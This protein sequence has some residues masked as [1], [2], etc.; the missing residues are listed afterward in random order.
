MAEQRI[1]VLTEG[2]S[3]PRAAKTATS[4]I[5]YR[6]DEVVA[7]LDSTQVGQTSQTLLGVGGD[8]PVV[9]SLGDAAAADTLLIG[10]SPPGGK[11]PEE[12]RRVILDAISRGMSVVSGLHDFLV[13]DPE[14]V[15]AAEE[16]RV[17]LVDVRKNDERIVA[18][19]REFNPDCLR[20]HTV[21][22]DCTVGK[23]LTAIDITN[24]LKLQGHDAKFVATGQTGIM[25]EGDGCPID[26]VVADFISGA[27]EQLVLDNHQHEILLIEGQG[28]LAHPSFSGV[29]LGLLHGVRPDGL[30]L[31]Y[32]IG[33]DGTRGVEHFPVIPLTRLRDIYESLASLL[34]P[35]R[36]IGV[37]INSRTVSADVA[38]RHRESVE[39][40]LGVPACDVV[41]DGPQMLVQAVLDLQKELHG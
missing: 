10:I 16:H 8:I 9:A 18:K 28:S 7:V 27:A 38:A 5:R 11:M 39:A 20:I 14:F 12:W 40:E 22:Q 1:V 15:A 33:R 32:E 26:C 23:M 21:G 24:Q 41:R 34:N 13:N 36:V 25:V 29:T 4:V 35:C 2:K 6:A 17:Q 31:C 3:D 30:I 19:Y 37:G